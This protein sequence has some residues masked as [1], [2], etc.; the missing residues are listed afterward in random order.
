M[1]KQRRV[2]IIGLVQIRAD[3][4]QAQRA[5]AGAEPQSPRPHLDA[6]FYGQ[7]LR[8]VDGQVSN[9]VGMLVQ[10]QVHQG[11]QGEVDRVGIKARIHVIL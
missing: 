9:E 6:V 1:V 3:S 7:L 8:G 5:G 4:H 11:L 10:A 2:C